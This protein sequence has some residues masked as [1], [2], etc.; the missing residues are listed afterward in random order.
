MNKQDTTFVQ[1]RHCIAFAD[2]KHEDVLTQGHQSFLENSHTHT[3][4]DHVT[5]YDTPGIRHASSF[6]FVRT[7]KHAASSAQIK[8]QRLSFPMHMHS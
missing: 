4:L 7:L 3:R 1:C 5:Q 2:N 8:A 6:L